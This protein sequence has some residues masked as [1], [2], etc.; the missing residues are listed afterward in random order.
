MAST[1]LRCICIKWLIGRLHPIGLGVTWRNQTVFNLQA[2]TLA[3]K[4]MLPTR[5]LLFVG[6]AIRQ[7]AAIVGQNR[8]DFNGTSTM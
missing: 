8:F 6:K 7:L 1:L 3:I 5:H 2:T 4:A